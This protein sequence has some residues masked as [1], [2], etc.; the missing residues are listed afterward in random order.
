MEDLLT[1]SLIGKRE[2]L[3]GLYKQK[4]CEM[5][6]SSSRAESL[7]GI[8]HKA[9]KAIL[10]GT[11]KQVGLAQAAK[12][13]YFL[14]LNMQEMA[15]SILS[16]ASVQAIADIENAKKVQLISTEF[17][18]PALTSIGFFDKSMD[19]RQMC[20]RVKTFFGY[21]DIREYAV[22]IEAAFSRTKRASNEKMRLF[23]VKCAI[24]LFKGVLSPYHYD[25]EA[26]KSLITKLRG[27]TQY[28]ERGLAA[29]FKELYKVG[30]TAIYQPA[31]PKTQVRGATMA[32]DRKPCVAISDLGNRYPTLW[33]ALAHELYHVLYDLDDIERQN[34]HITDDMGDLFVSEAQADDFAAQCLLSDDRLQLAGRYITSPVYTAQYARQIGVHPSVIY[35]RHCYQTKQW[36]IYN[37]HIPDARL[38]LAK[39]STVRYNERDLQE[40][41]EKVAQFY[42]V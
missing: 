36:R 38:A 12:L 39:I 32:I 19:G 28:E 20:E 37:K 4:I 3:A 10:E 35:A 17:D 42:N 2:D 9:L 1:Q 30:V 18:I 6:I 34:F 22:D 5:G 21:D 24:H 14:G 41:I 27:Y 23:W 29:V 33:F 31:I 25:R 11:A 40:T 13:A 16:G 26:L 8:D 15:A 7:L